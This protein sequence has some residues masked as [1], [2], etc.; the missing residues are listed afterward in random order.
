MRVCL[1]EDRVEFFEPLSLTR[2]VFELRCGLAPLGTRL[3]QYLGATSSGVVIRPHLAELYRQQNAG[4]AVNDI[5]WLAAGPVAVVNGL[6]LPPDGPPALGSEPHAGFVG[7]DLAYVYAGAEQARQLKSETL[8]SALAGW[9]QTLTARSVGGH[10]I[11]FPWDLVDHNGAQIG[12]DLVGPLRSAKDDSARS[13][14]SLP[15]ALL[16]PVE[17][18]H[19]DP[20][21]RI[22]PFVTADAT[23]GPVVIDE[24]AVIASFTR[25]EGPC[26]IGPNT[27]V[28]GAK[29]R[30]GTSL[31]PFCRIGGEVECSIV[32][33]YSNKYHDGF[34]GHSYVGEWV[35]LA[36]G[37]SNSDL[38]A[39]YGP[40]SVVLQRQS[41][42]TGRTKVGCFLGDHVKTGL[43][44]LINTGASVGVFAN[45]FPSG[46]LAPKY[47]PSFVNFS[48]GILDDG[49][50]LETLLATAQEM[51]NRRQYQLTDAHR[52]LYTFLLEETA[53]TRQR[54]LRDARQKIRYA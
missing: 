28:F 21:A 16:G 27:Q 19:V 20:S 10:I 52:R 31:G 23:R 51:M 15:V 7:N 46:G 35:N 5:D 43:G 34:L 18:L 25:L 17:R 38:R 47:V 48:R 3:W 22:E 53:P 36:A 41:I 54:V 45:L 44:T 8:E 2:P 49:F 11:Q 26:H 39:D 42:A 1:F 12:R 14:S 6:W 32:H 50:P 13:Q 30:A 24:G 9:K 4:L 40:V 29:I 33:S 37:T